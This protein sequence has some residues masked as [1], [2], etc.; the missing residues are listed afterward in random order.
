M[1]KYIFIY[2]KLAHFFAKWILY[3]SNLL[4]AYTNTLIYF[5]SIF[6]FVEVLL[7]FKV[8]FG[9]EEMAILWLSYVM[10]NNQN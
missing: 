5:I 2:F 8:V 10:L 7:F 6:S 3:M 9:S 1:L 4:L